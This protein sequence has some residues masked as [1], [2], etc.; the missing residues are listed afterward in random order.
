MRINDKNYDRAIMCGFWLVVISTFIGI[1]WLSVF[2]LVFGI[3]IVLSTFLTSHPLTA[4]K[5]YNKDTK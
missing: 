5:D 4:D 1:K 3:G 2:L